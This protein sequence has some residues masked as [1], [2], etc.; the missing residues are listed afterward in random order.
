MYRSVIFALLVLVSGCA[1]G[2]AGPPGGEVSKAIAQAKTVGVISAVG[3]KF[4]L[5]KV[6]ITV[7]GNELNEVAIGSWG[8]DDVAASKVSA[9]LSKRYT[10]KRISVPQA[11]AD[12]IE[13]VLRQAGATQKCDLY[14]VVT[15]GGAALSGT[16]QFVGGLG[17]VEHGHPDTVF[18]HALLTIRLYDG[19]TFELLQSRRALNEYGDAVAT[20]ISGPHRKLDRTWWPATPQ[21]VHNERLKGATRA[22]LSE[23]LARTVPEMVGMTTDPSARPKAATWV[24]FK[25]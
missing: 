13:A 23:G 7:F 17:L 6:G 12:N 15:P 21:A 22:L 8:L 25:Q 5:Q 10:V 9:L 20:N 1:G 11:S 24:P 4:A 16:N 3:H 18:L 14:I 19:H 2:L